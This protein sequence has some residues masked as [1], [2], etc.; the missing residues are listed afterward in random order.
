MLQNLID[1]RQLQL[2]EER[3]ASFRGTVRVELDDLEFEKLPSADSSANV[4]RLREIFR[5]A[6]CYPL[7]PENRIVAIISDEKLKEILRTSKVT[8]HQLL[9]NPDGIPP[10]VKFPAHC[11]LFCLEGRSRVE[12]AKQKILPPGKKHWA[13]DLYLEDASADLR[14]VLS[15]QYTNQ[16]VYSDLEIYYNIHQYHKEGNVFAEG[17]WRARLSPNRQRNLKQ[18]L[19]HSML[20]A[21]LNEV[22]T[23][24]GQRF[25]FTLSMC[26]EVITMKCDEEFTHYFQ[27]IVTIWSDIL[28]GDEEM[29]QMTDK[30]TV[31]NLQLR[32]PGRCEKDHEF[33]KPLMDDGSLF[34]FVTDVPRRNRI[35]ENI[36]K[37]S[38]L[39]PSLYGLGEDKKFLSP[40]AKILKRLFPVSPNQT[41]RMAMINSFKDSNQRSGAV[42]VQES[43]WSMRHYKGSLTQQLHWGI[44]QL[45]LFAGRD[46]TLF[47]P[48]TPLKERGRPT[49]EP[50]RP[51]P[52]LW[53]SL[54]RLASDLGF[55]NDEIQ[56]LLAT[57]PDEK[58]TSAFLL[59]ARKPP[60]YTFTQ[61]QFEQNKGRIIRIL[62]TAKKNTH[63]LSTPTLFVKRNGEGLERRCGRHWELAYEYDH[64]HTFLPLFWT[65]DDNTCGEGIS[66]LFVRVAVYKA[67]FSDLI[68]C[69]T[70]Q[71]PPVRFDT[72]EEQPHEDND[73]S[74]EMSIDSNLLPYSQSSET[75]EERQNEFLQDKVR[76]LQLEVN[77]LRADVRE[78]GKAAERKT[79]E[80]L[81]SA[82]RQLQD[83]KSANQSLRGQLQQTQIECRE[84]I[85][86]LERKNSDL[87]REL[88]QRCRE[89]Q[90]LVVQSTTN[91][92]KISALEVRLS[93]TH[94]ALGNITAQ[95]MK[96]RFDTVQGENAELRNR[97]Q[98]ALS[99]V[100]TARE[101][102]E[103]QTMSE[104]KDDRA[105]EDIIGLIQTL[106][107]E[108]CY[109]GQEMERMRRVLNENQ[110]Q[111][112]QI[113][114]DDLENASLS[115]K[116]EE[117]NL[118]LARAGDGSWESNLHSN[119][120]QRTLVLHQTMQQA[121]EVKDNVAK[122]WQLLKHGIN[123]L[124]TSFWTLKQGAHEAQ[125]AQEQKLR[126]E[127]EG[128][129]SEKKEWS[130]VLEKANSDKDQ[131]LMERENLKSQ[132]NA[133]LREVEERQML[134]NSARQTCEALQEEVTLK[135]QVSL[136][137]SKP[138][139]TQRLRRDINRI[140]KPRT[141]LK[142]SQI[143][144]AK[145]RK[146]EPAIEAESKPL[147]FESI[148]NARNEKTVRIRFKVDRDRGG[149]TEVD[150]SRSKLEDVLR[151][152]KRQGLIPHDTGGKAMVPEDAWDIINADGTFTVVFHLLQDIDV[153][154]GF[155]RR[156]KRK[157]KPNS[158]KPTEE[159]DKNEALEILQYILNGT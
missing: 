52:Y 79:L 115:L 107:T 156:R 62:N 96:L 23:I 128:F 127:R 61:S 144:R 68:F 10:V 32:V 71:I 39:I 103:Q 80:N 82:H 132:V 81:D 147:D 155:L 77:K 8:D 67:F 88:N 149:P 150:L 51:D 4:A 37:V 65:E 17:R 133:L 102:L 116:K 30:F 64:D 152:C 63:S 7:E 72:S 153:D 18:F 38:T 47:I 109:L 53:T 159:K 157:K 69:E 104:E 130:T 87:Q 2:C 95:Q 142:H 74:F 148:P 45:F 151:R 28:D 94:T 46:F 113:K 118:Q 44:F 55:E 143:P 35:W 110:D 136:L 111:I 75:K 114:Y 34:S 58:A 158:P 129:Q 126:D 36:L 42:C 73:V 124:G 105:K 41:L 141:R 50:K 106:T 98:K 123:A 83:Y 119:A 125:Q 48:E 101:S 11:P 59:Q 29:M 100:K 139:D 86:E 99:D 49:P 31:E 25:G 138:S 9:E 97:L 57:D 76:M 56:K 120:T 60:I 135:T 13:V 93:E 33:V 122:E 134:L 15:E 154:E 121:T 16:R 43:D 140:Q 145:I 146:G 20:P 19:K 3:S 85:V 1:Q 6:G 66:S 21:A 112:G 92:N 84:R 89:N 5:T 24:P 108:L 70:M 26:H 40:L 131:A 22:L 12:A 78:E 14:N 91:Q 90:S 27:H 54:A 137:G 117:L